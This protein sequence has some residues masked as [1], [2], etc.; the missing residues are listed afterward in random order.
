MDQPKSWAINIINCDICCINWANLWFDS[1]IASVMSHL[2][3]EYSLDLSK[4]NLI[5]VSC[6]AFCCQQISTGSLVFLFF[7]CRFFYYF[8]FVVVTIAYYTIII[9]TISWICNWFM[10][11]RQSHTASI[12]NATI[13]LTAVA[14]TSC[15]IFTT[16]TTT[17]TCLYAN[18]YITSC[19]NRGQTLN[20]GWATP[21]S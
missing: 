17:C 10:L 18:I 7:F 14:Y 4:N 1:L 8:I 3:W 21:N 5:D 19:S 11:L 16:I 13:I 2:N 6:V 15:I 9:N 20:T 12:N